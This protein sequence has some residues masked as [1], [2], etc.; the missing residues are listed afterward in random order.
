MKKRSGKRYT[1]YRNQNDELIA[2]EEPSDT[3]AKLMG[4]SLA[5]FYAIVNHSERWGYTIIK[6]DIRDWL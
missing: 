5:R 1:V 3:C 6:T 2:F 4:I